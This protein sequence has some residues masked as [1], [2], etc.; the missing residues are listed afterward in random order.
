MAVG[1]TLR[2]SLALF[3]RYSLRQRAF[4]PAHIQAPDPSDATVRLALQKLSDE[5]L[6][7]L[8]GVAEDRDKGISR[9]LS[10]RETAALEAYRGALEATSA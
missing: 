7:L 5:Q 6:D 10:E 2:V 4:F 1:A 8:Q 3:L 9:I